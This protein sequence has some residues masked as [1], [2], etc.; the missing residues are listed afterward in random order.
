MKTGRK[1]REMS[2]KK[3]ER[4]KKKDGNLKAKINEKQATRKS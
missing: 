4:G 3:K 2:N 1:R